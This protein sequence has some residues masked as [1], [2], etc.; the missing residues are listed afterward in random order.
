[1]LDPKTVLTEDGYEEYLWH[2]RAI[3]KSLFFI[4]NHSDDLGIGSKDSKQ[5]DVL[6]DLEQLL[7]VLRTGDGETLEE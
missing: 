2:L 7:P 3:K 5:S 6:Y 4:M 1:M